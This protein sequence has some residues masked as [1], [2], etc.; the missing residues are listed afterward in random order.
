MHG[1]VNSNGI[2]YL[3]AIKAMKKFTTTSELVTSAAAAIV[4]EWHGH[5]DLLE[6]SNNFGATT[7]CEQGPLNHSQ[8]LGVVA[9]W[10]RS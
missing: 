9:E 7:G 1:E 2:L 8:T 10:V 5:Q 4:D 3:A 6:N